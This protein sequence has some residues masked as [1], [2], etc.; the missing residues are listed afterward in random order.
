VDIEAHRKK[1]YVRLQSSDIFRQ[2]A[3]LY[4]TTHLAHG[5]ARTGGSAKNPLGLLAV[6]LPESLRSKTPPSIA[7]APSS[8]SGARVLRRQGTRVH[9]LEP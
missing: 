4:L 6:S 8:V 1:G 9:A 2:N 5:P 3:G 7:R